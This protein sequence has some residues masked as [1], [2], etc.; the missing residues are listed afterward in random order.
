MGL[1][2][3]TKPPPCVSSRLGT[4]GGRALHP[5][6]SASA[7]PCVFSLVGKASWR[8]AGLALAFIR[9]ESRASGRTN[10]EQLCPAGGRGDVRRTPTEREKKPNFLETQWTEKHWLTDKS[11]ATRL[12]PVL[13]TFPEVYVHFFFFLN[14]KTKQNSKWVFTSTLLAFWMSRVTLA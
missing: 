14:N 8:H 5:P 7:P 2:P 10:L 4:R 1:K 13:L 3:P 9:H 11:V 12:T 6:S